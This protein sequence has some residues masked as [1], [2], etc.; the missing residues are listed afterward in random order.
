VATGDGKPRREWRVSTNVVAVVLVLLGL[1]TAV[2]GYVVSGQTKA[3][4]VCQQAYSNGFADAFD[5]RAEANAQA[6]DAL[7]DWM[8]VVGAVMTSPDSSARTRLVEAT[9]EYLA[10]RVEARKTQAEHPFP[11]APRDACK[12]LEGG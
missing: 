10:K 6:Q 11:P 12:Q 8:T 9:T 5:A 2:Q 1:F 7:D 4:A 3:L